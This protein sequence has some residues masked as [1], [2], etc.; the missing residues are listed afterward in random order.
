MVLAT[1]TTTTAPGGGLWELGCEECWFCPRIRT[2]S[3]GTRWDRPYVR[4]IEALLLSKETVLLEQTDLLRPQHLWWLRSHRSALNSVLKMLL[5]VSYRPQMALLKLCSK[6][7]VWPPDGALKLTDV[8]MISGWSACSML[9][10]YQLTTEEPCGNGS[11]RIQRKSLKVGLYA[12]L[13]Y[14]LLGWAQV[15]NWMWNT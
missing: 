2:G 9:M 6:S 1:L 4:E 8:G 14:I 13:K 15:Y 7:I 3:K 12:I 5:G 10:G 11:Q